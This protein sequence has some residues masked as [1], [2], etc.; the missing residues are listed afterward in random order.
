MIHVQ[1]NPTSTS[2]GNVRP[3]TI[4]CCNPLNPPPPA[5]PNPPAMP[6]VEWNFLSSPRF[7]PTQ[8]TTAFHFLCLIPFRLP[9]KIN[10]RIL[11]YHH[12]IQYEGF[13]NLYIHEVKLKV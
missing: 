5:A 7:P 2:D 1:I 10:L 6:E 3:R 8:A 12:S 11:P 13:W 9:L 4:Y